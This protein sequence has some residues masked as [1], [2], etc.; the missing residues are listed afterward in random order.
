MPIKEQHLK[1]RKFYEEAL[2]KHCCDSYP[3][4]LDFQ[5]KK[6][7]IGGACLRRDGKDPEMPPIDESLDSH[8][9][10]SQEVPASVLSAFKRHC[11]YAEHS[12]S[13][14]AVYR[15][16]VNQA[17]TFAICIHGLVNDGWDNG[18][19]LIEIYDREG[20]LV[21]S[22]KVPTDYEWRRWKWLSRPLQGDDFN[23]SAP[24]QQEV[25]INQLRMGKEM[26]TIAACTGLSIQEIQQISSR[27][28]NHAQELALHMLSKGAAI[29]IIALVTRLSIEEIQQLQ[30]QTDDPL[31]S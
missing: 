19:D 14:I 18:G 5:P 13:D 22:A 15:I 11:W 8:I 28:Y 27:L 25:A 6:Y 9:D 4:I 30:Q 1:I 31:E 2:E 29:D 17:I 23:T 7:E 16:P 26:G 12:L 20:A 21:G 3:G 24:E 10:P